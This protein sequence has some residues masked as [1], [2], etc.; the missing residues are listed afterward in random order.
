MNLKTWYKPITGPATRTSKQ[1][2]VHGLEWIK[3]KTEGIDRCKLH[4]N[5]KKKSPRE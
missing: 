5:F 3:G 2:S 1:T 4:I